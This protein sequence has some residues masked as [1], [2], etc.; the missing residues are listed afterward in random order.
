MKKKF[1]ILAAVAVSGVAAVVASNNNKVF[2]ASDADAH[3]K[4]YSRLGT[5]WYCIDDDHSDCPTN[6]GMT[7]ITRHL[8]TNLL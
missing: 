4:E 7:V 3:T 2:G 6:D 8:M 5:T 1:L